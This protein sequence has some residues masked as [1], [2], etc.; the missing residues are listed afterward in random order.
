[1]QEF[2]LFQK[3]VTEVNAGVLATIAYRCHDLKK[4]AIVGSSEMSEQVVTEWANF[5]FLIYK[6]EAPLQEVWLENFSMHAY[7]CNTVLDSLISNRFTHGNLTQ[8]SLA[9]NAAWWAHPSG[10]QNIDLLGQL[11]RHLS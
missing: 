11:V 9:K 3:T 2:S 1:M 4:L 5:V 6:Q 8:L 7:H 10:Q